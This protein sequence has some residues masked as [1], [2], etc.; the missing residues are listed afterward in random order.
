M[1]SPAI[2]DE[3]AYPHSNAIKNKQTKQGIEEEAE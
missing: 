2:L 1:L 3:H